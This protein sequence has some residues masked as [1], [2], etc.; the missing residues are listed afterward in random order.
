KIIYVYGD[1]PNS[2]SIVDYDDSE[3]LDPDTVDFVDATIVDTD[4][5]IP[6]TVNGAG[7]KDNSVA[8]ANASRNAN[9]ATGAA[10]GILIPAAAA[11]SIF[12]VKK[13][14]RRRGRK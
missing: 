7:S 1:Q 3:E 10:A 2:S 9:P 5:Y 11:A 14:K 12:L 6:S 8:G 13:D 4:D